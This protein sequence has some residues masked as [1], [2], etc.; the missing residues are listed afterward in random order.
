MDHFFTLNLIYCYQTF[1][2]E[3][4][5]NFLYSRLILTLIS[6]ILLFHILQEI[7]HYA[8]WR[9]KYSFSVSNCSELFW[10]T[11][12]NSKVHIRNEFPLK[13]VALNVF[14]CNSKASSRKSVI[15]RILAWIKFFMYQ[16]RIIFMFFWSIF[17]VMK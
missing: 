14:V 10:D 1:S 9:W 11:P 12:R 7:P 17:F 15:F 16:I 13:W 3:S 2:Q 4:H 5:D 8:F 6:V